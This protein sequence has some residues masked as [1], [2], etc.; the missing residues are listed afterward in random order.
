MAAISSRERWV[1]SLHV[2]ECTVAMNRGGTRIIGHPRPFVVRHFQLH[3]LEPLQWRYNG[4]DG[5][6]NH[7]RLGCLLNRLFRLKSRP[8][9]TSKLCVTG[10]CEGNSPV[11]GEFP[12]QRASNADYVSIWWRHHAR[13]CVTW[14]IPE[15]SKARFTILTDSRIVISFHG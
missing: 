3:F 7:R 11:T 5:V 1:N 15:S 9:K 4:R 13:Q 2:L 10:L 6:S 8:K 12:T 14:V